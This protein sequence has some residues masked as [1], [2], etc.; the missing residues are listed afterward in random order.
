MQNAVEDARWDVVIKA[1]K[2]SELLLERTL[3]A[4]EAAVVRTVDDI[5]ADNTSILQY[6]DE[7]SLARVLTLAYYTAKKDFQFI[8]E[9]P[10]G[11]GFADIVLLPNR[12]ADYPA[13]V[14]GLKYNHSADT[15]ITQIHE[16]RYVDSLLDYVGEIVLVGINYDKKTKHHTCKIEKIVT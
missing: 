12:N 2:R 15:A 4:D 6:K 9:L 13:V 5:H 8:R 7:N 16:K 1:I 3:A 11:L 10:S 14:L